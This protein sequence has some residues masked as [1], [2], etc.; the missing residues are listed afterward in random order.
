MIGFDV[1]V[2]VGL[3]VLLQSVHRPLGMVA[4]AFRLIQAAIL[5]GNL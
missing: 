2:A 5:G 1:A 3:Y 4:A